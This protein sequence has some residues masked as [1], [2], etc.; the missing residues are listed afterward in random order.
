MPPWLRHP[1]FPSVAFWDLNGRHKANNV[2][3]YGFTNKSEAEFILRTLLLTFSHLFLKRSDS[4][5][6]VGVISFYKD[7]VSFMV[8]SMTFLDHVKKISKTSSIHL[9]DGIKGQAIARGVYVHFCIEL[10][11]ECQDCNCG[12]CVENHI[13]NTF[14]LVPHSL[15]QQH[16]MNWCCFQAFKVQSA[17]SSSYHVFAH[18]P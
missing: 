18:T 16:C 1:C 4:K 11:I 13:T 9:D 14:P 12:W 15:L 3:G 6:S 8:I 2:K 17:I 5:V 10:K 7:Q